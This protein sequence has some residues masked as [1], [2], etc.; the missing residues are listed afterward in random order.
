M[1]VSKRCPKGSA[2]LKKNKIC[3][4]FLNKIGIYSCILLFFF[5]SFLL[6]CVLGFVAQPS[7]PHV[8]IQDLKL[9]MRIYFSIKLNGFQKNRVFLQMV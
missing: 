4:M 8:K 9:S 5:I 6:F 1:N 2:F 3:Y 7:F